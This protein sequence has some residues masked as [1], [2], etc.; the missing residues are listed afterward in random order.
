V[1]FIHAHE[2]LRYNFAQFVI[3]GYIRACERGFLWR[4]AANIA[5]ASWPKTRAS[6]EGG[7]NVT[8]ESIADVHCFTSPVF[9]VTSQQTNSWRLC[10][11]RPR[12]KQWPYQLRFVHLLAILFDLLKDLGFKIGE[13]CMRTRR[14]ELSITVLCAELDQW[15]NG[16][17]QQLFRQC[18]T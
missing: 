14:F 1:R 13:N 10:I 7:T 11:S 6:V 3:R 4:P 18:E 2:A 15:A 8:G 16:F 17:A 5:P 9:E 12:Q